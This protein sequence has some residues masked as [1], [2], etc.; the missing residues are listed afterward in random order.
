MI[1]TPPFRAERFRR[2]LPEIEVAR[3][4]VAADGT[5]VENTEEVADLS[6]GCGP[7]QD[8]LSFF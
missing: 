8:R 3:G 1:G 4:A 6:W 5:D 2:L 7:S